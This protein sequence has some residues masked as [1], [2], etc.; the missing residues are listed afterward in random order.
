[1]KKKKKEQLDKFLRRNKINQ[2]GHFKLAQQIRI[3]YYKRKNNL[4]NF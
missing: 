2:L 1:M 4:T 3:N